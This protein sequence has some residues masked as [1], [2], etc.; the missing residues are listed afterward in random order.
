M[1]RVR[2]RYPLGKG[3]RSMAKTYATGTLLTCTHEQCGCRVLIQEQCNC[4]GA[5]NAN[6]TCACG[7][8]LVPVS[9]S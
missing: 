5:D 3:R 2:V 9:E 7:A 1:G 4:E 8:K 6:Y